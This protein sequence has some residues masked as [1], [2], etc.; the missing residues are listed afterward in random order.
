MPDLISNLTSVTTNSCWFPVE[1][2]VQKQQIIKDFQGY[3][4]LCVK[5]SVPD[6]YLFSSYTRKIHNSKFY[7]IKHLKADLKLAD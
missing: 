7:W 5:T 2:V 3:P 1:A 4:V 6:F